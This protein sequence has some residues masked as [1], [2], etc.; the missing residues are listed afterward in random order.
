M[1]RKISMNIAISLNNK[2]ANYAYVLLTSIF[3]NNKDEN[4]TIYA[5]NCD[6][7]AQNIDLLSSFCNKYNNT[8]NPIIV[9]TSLL[10]HLPTTHMWSR[11]AYLRLALIDIIPS[12]IERILY[13]DID[14]IVLGSLS[15]LYN[16]NFEDKYFCVCKEFDNNSDVA[17]RIVQLF[18]GDINKA[19]NYFNSGMMLWNISKLRENNHYNLSYYIRRNNE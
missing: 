13:L 8:F 17:E 9:E 12:S 7:N 1:S 3:E 11:E 10:S 2:Y 5:L 6:L 4:I 14:M 15:E 19:R 16:S 18:D